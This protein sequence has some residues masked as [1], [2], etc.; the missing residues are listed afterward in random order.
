MTSNDRAD[1]VVILVIRLIARILLKF[2]G[3]FV[4]RLNL[5]WGE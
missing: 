5:D 1:H 2:D 4:P 3:G